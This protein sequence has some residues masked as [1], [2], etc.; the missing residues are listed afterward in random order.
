MLGMTRLGIPMK[1]TKLGMVSL[2]GV[3]PSLIPRLHQQAMG[4]S[5]A[6]HRGSSPET[7]GLSGVLRSTCGN[8]MAWGELFIGGRSFGWMRR[9]SQKGMSLHWLTSFACETYPKF[10]QIISRKQYKGL[11]SQNGELVQ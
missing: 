10:V 7:H 5:E 6:L 1:E 4:G 2:L 3:V 9:E 11:H 8:D